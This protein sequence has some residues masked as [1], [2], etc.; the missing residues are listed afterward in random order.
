MCS[1][2]KSIIIIVYK[3]MC[4]CNE[5][6]IKVSA[7]KKLKTFHNC[8]EVWGNCSELEWVNCLKYCFRKSVLAYCFD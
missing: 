8:Y 6:I 5:S 3:N 2:N 1:Y 7:E 4:S